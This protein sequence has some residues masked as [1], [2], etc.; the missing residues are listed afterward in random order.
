MAS[1]N[2][3]TKDYFFRLAKDRKTT[4]EF[5]GMPLKEAHINKI[6]EAARWAPSC[7]NV[8]PWNFIVVKNKERI[9]K[10]IET[11]SFGAF[12]TPP[13]VVI[14][15][16]LNFECWENSSHR[17]VKNDKL[18]TIEAFLCIAMPALNMVFEAQ[19]LG[20]NTAIIT[21]EMGVISKLLKIRKSDFVPLVIAFGYEKK[22]A[23]QKK[24][25][26]KPLKEL[27]YYETFLGRRKE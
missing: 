13:P 7:S 1:K 20:I 8:Q 5:D 25:V 9:S 15:L 14:A 10:I 27:V 6:L 3:S 17:C 12:H 24:R 26:R 11:A 18:G 21:P 19:E 2:Y 16:V 4:Y 22:G 23:F